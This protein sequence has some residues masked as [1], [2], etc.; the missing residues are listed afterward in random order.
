MDEKV[1]KSII[2]GLENGSS[3]ALVTL[4]MANGSTPRKNGSLMSVNSDGIVAGSIGGGAVEHIVLKKA[5]EC[6]KSGKDEKFSYDLN[7]NGKAK[8]ICGGAVEGYIK[9]FQTKPTLIIFGGGHI[10]QS[11]CRLT[12]SMN[13]RRIVVEDREELKYEEAFKNIDRFIVAKEMEEIEDLDFEDSYIVVATRGH[14]IDAYW[15]KEL[16]DKKYNYLGILGSI[17]KVIELKEGLINAGFSNEVIERMH[18]PIGLD[19][20]DGTPEEIGISILSEI[21]LVKNN[22]NLEHLQDVKMRALK[23]I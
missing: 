11:I 12:D 10:S 19:I 5:L 14:R 8:M 23:N 9:V 21:L 7:A 13:F 4:T 15:S 22:G 16:V 20:A 17:K 3:M 6:I 1:L 18:A 2:E